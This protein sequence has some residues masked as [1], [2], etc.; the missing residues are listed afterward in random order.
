MKKVKIKMLD[1]TMPTVQFG[2]LLAKTT[3]TL[4][5][6]FADWLVKS[7]KAATVVKSAKPDDPK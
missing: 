1:K 3:Y 2:T 4:P 5:K 7:M 6:H